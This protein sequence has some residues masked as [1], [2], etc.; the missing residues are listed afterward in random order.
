[1]SPRPQHQKG[2]G[3]GNRRGETDLR[4]GGDRRGPEKL[5]SNR[6]SV[7]TKWA[8]MFLTGRLQTVGVDFV[9]HMQL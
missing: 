6:S 1:M 3:E 7:N 4:K 5:S 8:L 2:E 9:D